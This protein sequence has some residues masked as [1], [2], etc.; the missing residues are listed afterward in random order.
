MALGGGTFTYQNKALPG[1]YINFV[2]TGSASASLSDRG[3]A[4][5]ALPLSWG[6]LGEII[7][8]TS[9]EFC[10][11]SVGLFGYDYSHSALAG[12]RDLFLYADTCYIYRLGAG[13]VKASSA[14]GTAKYEGIRGNDIL[15]V[16]SAEDEGF[17][18]K[19]YLAGLLRDSQVVAGAGELID[20]DFVVFDTSA[21]LEITAGTAF[22][23]GSDGSY[24]T[25]DYQVFLS[26]LEGYSFNTLG[27]LSTDDAVKRLFVSFTNRMRD[28]VGVK[29]QCVLY[30]Y[31]E[32]DCEGIISV[33]NCVGG[34][35]GDSSAVFWVTGVCAG[36][37]LNRSNTNRLYNG[38]FEVYADYTQAELEGFAKGGSFILH[39]VSGDVRVL[40][41]INTFVS[42]TDEKSGD[43]SMNQTIRILDQIAA[44]IASLFCGKYLGVIPNDNAGRISLWN[45]IVSHHQRL[46]AVRAIEDFS[47]DD[48]TVSPGDS[49][50]CVVVTDYITPVCAM[51]RLYMTVIVN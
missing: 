18:V 43:F 16:V 35:E 5:I 34:D 45:D 51:S 40:E 28:D 20:N 37:A 24:S 25:A 11:N 42:V 7:T 9:E 44:D 32:A 47:P 23:G 49:K 39:K 13:G 2:S 30:R 50:T 8:V 17:C 19:T 14:L 1:S 15:V 21:V 29:F 6:A 4:A 22:T 33:H 27:C 31:P 3:F 38:E 26:K 36:C 12:L 46:A 41:D 48:I 10:N